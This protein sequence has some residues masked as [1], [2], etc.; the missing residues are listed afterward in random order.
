MS[1]DRRLDPTLRPSR[2]NAQSSRRPK[3]L[4]Y[5]AWWRTVFATLGALTPGFFLALGIVAYT[6]DRQP[7]SSFGSEVVKITSLV[8]GIASSH[9][10]PTTD[11]PQ[12][13]SAY[14]VLFAALTG[15]SLRSIALKKAVR[16]T[17]LG[18]LETVRMTATLPR[19]ILTCLADDGQL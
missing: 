4:Q 11:P 12:V 10:A 18:E 8:S 7:I 19:T 14:P 3:H 16:G 6:L 17:T 15:F 1:T 2:A 9:A 13:P 5:T